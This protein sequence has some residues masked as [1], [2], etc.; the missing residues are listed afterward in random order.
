MAAA[1]RGLNRF[2]YLLGAAAV[3]GLAVLGVLVLRK[4]PISIPAKVDHPG[5]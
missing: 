3:V 5:Q 1:A 2:Y 4:P